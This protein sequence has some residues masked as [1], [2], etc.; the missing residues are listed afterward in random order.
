M[1]ISFVVYGVPQSQGSIRAF[2]PK[3]AKHPVLTSTN[4]NLKSWR[5]DMCVAAFDASQ[6]VPKGYFPRP[7]AVRLKALFF[8]QRPK[9]AKGLYKITKSDL[10]KLVRAVGDS[11]TGIVYDDDSQIVELI[12]SKWY[13]RIPRV[14]ITVEAI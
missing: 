14:E 1:S 5:Q 4:K 9:S 2:M 11:L 10:D 8:F 13:D 6:R 12:A 3:G 7:D